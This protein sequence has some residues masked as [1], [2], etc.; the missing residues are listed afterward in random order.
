MTIQL[1]IVMNKAIK[2]IGNTCVFCGMGG[3]IFLTMLAI[4]WSLILLLS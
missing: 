1:G 3:A 4:I 2:A